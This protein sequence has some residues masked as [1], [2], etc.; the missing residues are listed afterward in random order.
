MKK[1]ICTYDLLSKYHSTAI[2]WEDKEKACV[3]IS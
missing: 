3:L 2:E 1:Y